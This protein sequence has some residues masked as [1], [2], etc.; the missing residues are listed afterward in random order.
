VSAESS[1]VEARLEALVRERLDAEAP[2]LAAAIVAAVVE[3]LEAE[4]WQPPPRPRAPAG[5]SPTS[6]HPTAEALF[7]A[8]R[9]GGEASLRALLDLPMDALQRLIRSLG[10][11]PTGRARKWTKRDRFIDFLVEETMKR[12]K[13][14]QAFMTTDV[15]MPRV[16]DPSRSGEQK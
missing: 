8:A 7:S 13:R 2:R 15:D 12:V 1:S 3:A 11:D 9:K 6:P 14:N 10:Y 4:G 5:P 16:E